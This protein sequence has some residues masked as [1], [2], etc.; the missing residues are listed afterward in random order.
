MRSLPF[1]AI[2]FC[3]PAF[4]QL[5]PT[6]PA[7]NAPIANGTRFVGPEGYTW[8][9][10]TGTKSYNLTLHNGAYRIE[11]H[12]D[13]RWPHDVSEGKGQKNRTEISGLQAPM[14]GRSTLQYDVM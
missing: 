4:A 3:L 13:D 1:A 12:T 8:S 11:L 10:Q 6:K 5:Q 14:Q 2:L 9:A 7:D